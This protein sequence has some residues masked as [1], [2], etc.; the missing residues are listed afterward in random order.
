MSQ[1]K[2]FASHV[3]NQFQAMQATD[4]Y[5]STMTGQELW[6]LYLGSFPEGTN[7][8]FRERTEHDGSYDKNFIRRVGNVVA[9]KADGIRTLWENYES[10]PYPYNIVGEMLH[11]AIIVNEIDG[12]FLT[13]EPNAGHKP[14]YEE[15]DGRQHLWE[16][17]YV[18]FNK[19]FVTKSAAELIGQANTNIGVMAR[20][21]EEIT[22]S[23]I[24]TVLD[25]IQSNALYR[26]DQFNPTVKT[27]HEFHKLYHSRGNSLEQSV[28]LWANHK[29]GRLLIK[30]TVIGTLLMD[31]SGGMDLEDAVK[32]YEVKTAPTNYRRPTALITN[33]MITDAMATVDKLGIR[34]DLERRHA[35]LSDVSI[36]NVLWADNTAKSVMKDSIDELLLSSATKKEPK[37][38]KYNEKISIMDF[39]VDVL[40]KVTSMEI[41]F[42]N[43]LQKNLVSI[44]APVHANPGN[45][46]AP[47]FQWD[48]GFAW[49]YKGN[50]TDSIRERVKAA[51]GNVEA[52]LRVSLAWFNYDDLDLHCTSPYGHVFFGAKGGDKYYDFSGK[53]NILDVDMNA[54]AGRTRTPVENLA[55]NKPKD[56][57]YKIWVN[58]Y[59]KRETTNPGFEAQI[60]CKGETQHLS[61]DKTVPERGN[62]EIT[63]FTIKN[64]VVVGQTFNPALTNSARSQ[65]LWGVESERF[66]RVS[67]LMLSPNY[68]DDQAHTG[69]KHWFFIIDGMINPEPCR[70]IYNEFLSNELS[71]HRKVFEVLGNKT[72]VQPVA[73]AAEQLSGLGF[74][75]TVRSEVTVAVSGPKINRT[76]V[77][78]F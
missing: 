40:P 76:Y 28:L 4:L 71:K 33:S 72:M 55:F 15:I 19:K 21:A 52:D 74:N 35:R 60:Q 31:L 58:Q 41:L 23:A 57:D 36:N 61:Y 69:T 67:T 11:K 17:F 13:K 73:S 70:G 25:L 7:P 43:S 45:D 44:T 59:F 75:S 12:L 46:P 48:N 27:F 32:A 16:H 64:G 51:G 78:Q 14:N 66:V 22:E 62:V 49:S 42:S 54:G 30:N 26:G 34:D 24:T 10:F 50:V 65:V 37:G 68:W 56:G 9:I 6:D 5:R 8:I 3:H 77:V 47:L 18:E 29:D 63:S 1:F 53:Q 39:L 20:G 38:S 2:D